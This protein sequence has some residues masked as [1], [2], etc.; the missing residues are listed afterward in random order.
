VFQGLLRDFAAGLVVLFDDRYA[1]GDNV[2]LGG[3]S[4]EVVDLGVLSAELRAP[5]QR[6]VTVPNSRCEPVVNRTKLCSGAGLDLPRALAVV[7]REAMAFAANSAWQPLLLRPPEVRGVSEIT[8]DAVW[9]SVLVTTV[10][11]RHGAA[12]RALL[13][14]LVERLGAEGLALAASTG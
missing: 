11:G 5:D 4:G 10:A 1:I 13:G 12:Q 2:D 14:R 8:V 6:V 7:R 9:L 3:F